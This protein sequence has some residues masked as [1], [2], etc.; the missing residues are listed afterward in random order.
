M[1]DYWVEP[2]ECVTGRP[3]WHHKTP[4]D[5]KVCDWAGITWTAWH[6][7]WDQWLVERNGRE[8][9]QGLVTWDA[10]QYLVGSRPYQVPRVAS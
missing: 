5:R 10:V 8:L 6:L 2:H 3:C 7:G 1:D 4:G 9:S